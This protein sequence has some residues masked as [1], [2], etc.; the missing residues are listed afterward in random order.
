[1]GNCS[2]SSKPSNN[3]NMSAESE[4][5]IKNETLKHQVRPVLYCIGE[6]SLPVE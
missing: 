5:F 6:C 4:N 2:S 3:S 1:M